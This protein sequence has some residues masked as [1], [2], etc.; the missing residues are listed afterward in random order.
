V[1]D[2]PAFLA[3]IHARPADPLPRLIYA[4]WLDDQGRALDSA[5]QRVLARP[6]DDGPRL[7]YAEVCEN[8]ANDSAELPEPPEPV[9]GELRKL[10]VSRLR[11]RAEFVRVQL[12]IA[13]LRASGSSTLAGLGRR[14]RD[15]L[16]SVD[17]LYWVPS[18][19]RV[20][21]RLRGVDLWTWRRG[22]I[23][24]CVADG[25]SFARYGREVCDETPIRLVRLTGGPGSYGGYS[26]RL[27][28]RFPTITFHPYHPTPNALRRMWR[29]TAQGNR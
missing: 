18:A 9:A 1:P 16:A 26:K 5:L 20:A 29:R 2:D 10:V 27:H 4:D 15:L 6:E 8:I 25:Y 23:E 28:G 13:K 14:E 11:T 17:S 12:E 24:V 22:F 21:V 7:L 3:A 19:L